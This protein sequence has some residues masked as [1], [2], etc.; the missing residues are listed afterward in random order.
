ME[1]FNKQAVMETASRLEKLFIKYQ[2]PS[3]DAAAA[4]RQCK[5]LIDRAK[6]GEIEKATDERLP[7]G[8]FSAEFESIHIRDLYKAA[9]ELDMYLEGCESEEAFNKHMKGI[10]GE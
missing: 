5:P 3:G 9:S 8:Y 4:Y 7:G 2:D 1:T 6:N 10:L